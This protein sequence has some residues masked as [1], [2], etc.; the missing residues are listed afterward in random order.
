MRTTHRRVFLKLLGAGTAA[1]AVQQP[2][3][4][5]LAETSAS[6]DEFFIIIHQAGGWDVTLFA[7][8]RNENK[9]IIDP[10]TTELCAT[11]AIAH[12]IDQPLGDGTTS[13]QLVQKGRHVYGPAMGQ[14][15]D[16][17]DRLCVFNGI[18]M[19]TV[20]HPDGTYFSST[21]RHLSGG[22]PVAASIDT[23]LASEFGAKQLLPLMSVGF[24]S[25]YIGQNLDPRAMPLQVSNVTTVAK[26]ITRT[27]LYDT[28]EDRAAVTALLAAES[29]ELAKRAHLPDELAGFAFQYDA[30]GKLLG[31]DA[32]VL[33]D[34]AKLRAAHPAFNYAGTYQGGRVINAS[35]AIEAIRRRMLRCV[36]FAMSGCDTHNANYRNHP[37]ILQETFDMIAT[38]VKEMDGITFDGSNDKLSDHVHVLVVSEFCRTPQINLTNGRDHYPNNS[39]LVISPK[40]KGDHRYGK[41]DPEQLLPLDSGVFVDGSRPLTPADVLATFLS[42]FGIDP[43][44]YMRDGEVI[45]DVL[46]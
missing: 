5:A 8:P 12:W 17:T 14:L 41:S 30:L 27:S 13:F 26:S 3:L 6:P 24:P 25:T 9:G 18:S 19:N 4:R 11:Q 31:D 2:F 46:R 43:R 29:R 1:F 34:Q 7:D 40:F 22:R 16:L 32:K 28:A 23:M 38:L 15:L 44:K 42:A 37:M 45:H 39:A 33:F 35:F 21:G 10:A 36:S 20:S